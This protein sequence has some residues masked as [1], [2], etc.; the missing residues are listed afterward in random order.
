MRIEEVSKSFGRFK[1]LDAINISEIK[2]IHGFLGE[3]GAGKTTL[4]RI[5]ATVMEKDSGNIVHNDLFWDNKS[6]VRKIIGYLPQKFGFYHKLTV[7]E[8]VEHMA[9]LKE[10]TG[11]IEKEAERV[12]ELTNLYSKID[13]K[14]GALS[15]GMVRRLGIA[16]A[17]LGN[18]E[19]LIVDE[20]TAG[21]D[22]EERIRF[23]VL[24][25]EI[26]ANRIVLLSTHIVEDAESVCDRIT[27]LHNGRAI[28]TGTG[29]EISDLADGKVWT[30]RV[31]DEY[32]IESLNEKNITSR[33]RCND[34]Y[35]I[36]LISD[37]KPAEDAMLTTPSLE[38]GYMY[39]IHM[40]DKTESF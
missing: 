28:M 9:I 11:D 39:C 31:S 21:L 24:L 2:G 40:N 23:R 26:G 29:K 38:E 5:I 16:Q 6:E 20:P 12:I 15:G 34:G 37:N 36:R 33:K 3:N 8:V 32:I 13:T 7:R 18:P 4:M 10:V 17:I 19:I 22:P 27:V 25:H 14:V 1:A 35:E 30:L